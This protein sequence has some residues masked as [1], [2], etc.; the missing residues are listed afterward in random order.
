MSLG[1]SSPGLPAHLLPVGSVISWAG[2]EA[3]V[4]AGWLIC[5]GTPRSR[6]IYRK[7][8][9]TI[10]TTYGVGDGTA[11]FDLPSLNLKYAYGG[12][13][14]GATGGADTHDHPFTTNVS[15]TNI[16]SGD[17]NHNWN[18]S[19]LNNSGALS[20]AH[21][22]VVSFASGNANFMAKSVGNGVGVQGAAHTHAS[23]AIGTGVTGT[24]DHGHS[25]NA[26]AHGTNS[27]NHETGHLTSGSTFV[28]QATHSA[29]ASS[30]VA[31]STEQSAYQVRAI[32][33]AV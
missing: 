13:A 16:A 9:A 1:Y 30:Q 33:K 17:H 15:I 28:A 6:T 23:T 18:S 5:D 8:F 12:S 29:A 25:Q 21:N 32:I 14:T 11:T 24:Y 19:S 4:P 2:D 7:L 31:L 10:S 27:G 26:Q 3:V 20:H 22:G